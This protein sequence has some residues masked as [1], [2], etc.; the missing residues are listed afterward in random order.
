MTTETRQAP[1]AEQANLSDAS[2]INGVVPPPE[3]RWKPGQSGNPAGRPRCGAVIRDWLNVLAAQEAKVSD[4]KAIIDN[5]AEPATKVA[6]ARRL[7][8][9]TEASGLAEFVAIVEQTDGKPVQPA[10]LEVD[11]HLLTDSE[12]TVTAAEVKELMLMIEGQEK[13]EQDHIAADGGT[14]A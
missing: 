11:G 8:R 2:P 6:A 3:H 10:T 1:P 7:L 14:G 9:S 5:P 12:F 13:A 4:L